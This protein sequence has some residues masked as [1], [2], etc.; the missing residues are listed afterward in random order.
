MSTYPEPLAEVIRPM[1]LADLPLVMHNENRAYPHPWTET[2]MRDCLAG[3]YQCWVLESSRRRPIGHAIVQQV[4]DEAHL[5][6]LCIAP[7]WQG[8]GL[9]RQLLQFL[10]RHLRQQGVSQFFL[11]VRVSNMAAQELYRSQGFISVGLRKN[12]Y[13]DGTGREDGIVMV[14]RLV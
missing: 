12:Y 8:Q 1:R 3:D 5:L 6:N 10:E 13:P 9:G 11:E 2:V 14:H 7:E 4:L